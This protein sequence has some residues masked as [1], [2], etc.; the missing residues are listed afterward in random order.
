MGGSACTV[1]SYRSATR[2]VSLPKVALRTVDWLP[3]RELGNLLGNIMSL[4]LWMW[5]EWGRWTD[6]GPRAVEC[7]LNGQWCCSW[8]WLRRRDGRVSET[9]RPWSVLQKPS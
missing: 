8:S 5:Y 9:V 7:G 2:L 1:F 3:R 6:N 4:W